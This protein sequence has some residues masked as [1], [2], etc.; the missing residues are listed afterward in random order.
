MCQSNPVGGR[1]GF[2]VGGDAFDVKVRRAM[3]NYG[4]IWI[5]LRIRTRIAFFPQLSSEILIQGEHIQFSL[6]SSTK[7]KIR[8]PTKKYEA[9]YS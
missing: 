5:V 4:E 3:E 6:S 9:T 1:R 2:G 7:I 8:G